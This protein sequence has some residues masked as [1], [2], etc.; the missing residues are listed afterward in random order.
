[1]V[2]HITIGLGLVVALAGMAQ[3]QTIIY[4]D[5]S[6]DQ[7]PHDGSTWC[8]AYLE[9]YEALAAAGPD[10]VIRV[11]NGT[12]LPD[13]SGLG[14]PREATF[15]L[16]NGVTFEGRYG[17]CNDGGDLRDIEL[18]ETILSGDIGTPDDPNDNCYHVL[19]GS[20]TDASAVVDGFTITGGHANGP[21]PDDDGGGMYNDAGSPVVRYCTF[22][23]NYAGGDG[24]AVFN[25][26]SSPEMSCCTFTGN[27]VGDDGGA[28]C[29]AA[30]SAATI[31]NCA[32]VSNSSSGSG[33][34]VANLSSSP[35]LVNC[36]F[37]ANT[38]GTNGGAVF[39]HSGS[40][41]LTNCT[42]AANEANKG[43]GVYCR[44]NSS[45]T[46]TNCILW[47]DTPQEIYVESGDP[48]LTYCDVEGG[49]SGTGNIDADPLFVDPD[50]EDLHLQALSPCIDAGNT[51]ALP[52]GLYVD[53]DNGGR[54]L[55]DLCTSDTGVPASLV[56]ATVDMGAYEFRGILADLDAD[57]DVDL[58]DFAL[59]H[60][61][62]TGPQ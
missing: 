29:N 26:D 4:V 13:S 12:Y 44:L 37:S 35:V 57:G 18:Y 25:R 53:L 58:D 49:W 30:G 33:G 27:S 9:L 47:G 52:G 16:P 46:L 45:P 17:G 28:L 54:V 34:A 56:P 41:T 62:F 59:F 51:M 60:Q 36:I 10:T 8:H 3:G 32:F 21:S 19:I 23:E 15:Q 6:A 11:A 1:M 50:D 39:N 7:T 31:V 5:A 20:G 43:G 48:E 2:R 38:G 22:S 24:G 40:P 61:Q 14:D 42:I 55:D